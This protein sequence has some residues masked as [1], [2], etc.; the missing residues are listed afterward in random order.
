MNA[1]DISFVSWEIC[2]SRE[3]TKPTL[4]DP[5]YFPYSLSLILTPNNYIFFIFRS[6]VFFYHVKRILRKWI[7]TKIE[8]LCEFCPYFFNSVPTFHLYLLSRK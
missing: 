7:I 5:D 2:K 3:L 4:L 8:L 6:F 1:F